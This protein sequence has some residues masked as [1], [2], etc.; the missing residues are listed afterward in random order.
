[1]ALSNVF[2]LSNI[3]NATPSRFVIRN[4]SLCLSHGAKTIGGASARTA[5]IL[6]NDRRQ[7]WAVVGSGPY[8]VTREISKKDRPY[9][10]KN[11]STCLLFPDCGRDGDKCPFYFFCSG[12]WAILGNEINEQRRLVFGVVFQGNVSI[13]YLFRIGLFKETSEP[14]TFV[15]RGAKPID[16]NQWSGVP[17]V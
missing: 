2:R 15:G 8:F 9:S 5:A 14:S 3:S 7:N 17:H 6:S 16:A 12:L 13:F 10:S 11:T 4:L 1:M